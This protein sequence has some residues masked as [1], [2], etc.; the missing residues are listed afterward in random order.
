[1]PSKNNMHDN[2]SNNKNGRLEMK[3]KKNATHEH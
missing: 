1:M 3:C 2:L